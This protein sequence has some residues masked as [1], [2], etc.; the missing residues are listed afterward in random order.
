MEIALHV[1]C[2]GPYGVWICPHAGGLEG[3]GK[4]VYSKSAIDERTLRKFK[5]CWKY[6]SSE[7]NC[8]FS[9]ILGKLIS[10]ESRLWVSLKGS[11]L[12]F[13]RLL[14]SKSKP[15]YSWTVD[16]FLDGWRYKKEE[17]DTNTLKRTTQCFFLCFLFFWVFQAIPSLFLHICDICVRFILV[18]VGVSRII[19]YFLATGQVDSRSQCYKTKRCN[20]LILSSQKDWANSKKT[21]H[22]LKSPDI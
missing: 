1:L 7:V 21:L 9:D 4:K 8:G 15:L 2:V 19:F 16:F 17:K 11:P 5:R 13:L 18:F 20:M 12:G 14:L 22:R 6:P 10:V 3:C